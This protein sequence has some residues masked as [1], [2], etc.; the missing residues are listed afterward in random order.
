MD[1]DDSSVFS[2]STSAAVGVWLESLIL[3]IRALNYMGVYRADE[4]EELHGALYE[5][6]YYTLEVLNFDLVLA[7]VLYFF[8]RVHTVTG[9]LSFVVSVAKIG[10]RTAASNFFLPFFEDYMRLSSHFATMR[11]KCLKNCRKNMTL[12]V[13][14]IPSSPLLVS[15]CS[16]WCGYLTKRCEVGRVEAV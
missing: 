7:Q 2:F 4:Q 5:L 15:M 3:Y 6:S 10:R 9:C 8:K 1:T 11:G 13:F 12:R 14:S 16:F